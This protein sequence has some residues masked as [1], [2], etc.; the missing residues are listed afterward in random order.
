MEAFDVVIIGSGPGAQ[1]TWNSL[2]GRSVAVVE[3][4]LVGGNCPYLACVPSK[5]ML[6]T[7][8]VWGL[9]SNPEFMPVFLGPEPPETAYTM[10]VRRRDKLVHNRDDFEAAEQLRRAGHKLFRGHGRIVRPGVVDVSGVRIR[11]RDLVIDTG[12]VPEIP[13]VPGIENIEPWTSEEAMSSDGLPES[14]VVLGGGPVGCELSHLFALFGSVTTVVEKADRLLPREEPEVA[15]T[16]TEALHTV[17]GRVLPGATVTEISPRGTGVRVAL[18]TGRPV[19]AD[20]LL[21]AA[22]R[23]PYTIDLGLEEVG[24]QVRPGAPMPVDD[25]CRVVGAPHVWAVGDVTGISP[26]THTA[27]YQG[28]IVAANLMGREAVANYRAVPRAVYTEPALAAV[29]HTESSARAAGIEPLV[30]KADLGDTVRA[31]I[32]GVSTGWV[33]LVADPSRRTVIG[34]T[35]MGGHAEEFISEMSLAVRGDIPLSVL[36]DVVHPFPTFSE[37]LEGPLVELAERVAVRE[38][39]PV[40]QH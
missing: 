34:A 31:Q 27:E 14:I 30:A 33:K 16:L 26:H 18:D 35:A 12:S 5:A 24:L 13:P 19:D 36:T 20:K 38:P 29:G 22:G 2:P 37:V 17:D 23:V 21:L 11:Y 28:R 32:D 3:Q 39:V 1:M 10:T 15:D 4:G 6:Q 40:G 25:H 7:A 9:A 8:H